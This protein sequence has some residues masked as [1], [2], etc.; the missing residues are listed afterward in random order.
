MPVLNDQ[1][2]TIDALRLQREQKADILYKAQI[3]LNA[4]KALLD[5]AGRQETSLPASGQQITSL[6]S[7]IEDRQAEL[8]EL[9]SEY[10]AI[11]LVFEQLKQSEQRITFLQKKIDVI[12]AQLADANQNL[13]EEEEKQIPDKKIVTALTT[14]IPNLEKLLAEVEQTLTKAQDEDQ[15]LKQEQNAANALK[16]KLNAQRADLQANIE[17]LQDTLA[18]LLQ[19]GNDQSAA[20]IRKKLDQQQ[21]AYEQA[22][23]QAGLASAAV[24]AEV[25]KLYVD[26]HPKAGVSL[27]NDDTPFLLLPVRIETRFMSSGKQPELWLR[28]Y[29][30]DIAIHTHEKLLTTR[31]LAE[32]AVYWKALFEAEKAGGSTKEDMKKAA[33]STLART[34]RPQRSAWIALQTKPTNWDDLSSIPDADALVFPQPALTKPDSWSRAPRVNVLPDRFVITLYEGNVVSKEVVGNII[35]DELFVG[36]DP[37]EPDDSFLTKDDRLGFGESYDWTSDF[38]K[39]IKHGMG[40]K[41]PITA[42]QATKGFTRIIA[43]GV[44]LSASA[45]SGKKMVEDLIDNHHYSPKG[46]SLVPQGAATNNTD[47]NGSG[48][49]KN[50]SLDVSYVSETGTPLFTE[51][52]DCDGRNLADALGIDYTP[53]QN[54]LHSNGADLKE[55]V[56]MNKAL[57]ASTLGYYFDAMLKPVLKDADQD[58]LRDFFVENITGRG[59]LPAIRVGDQPYGILL[60]SNFEQWKTPFTSG[61]MPPGYNFLVRLYAI[62]KHYNDIW[63]GLSAKLSYVGKAGSDPSAALM[64]IIG[65]Q[66][67]SASIYQRIAYTTDY[68]KNLDEFQ[69]GGKYHAD[70]SASITSKAATLGFLQ[71]FGYTG[72]NGELKVPQLLRLIYQHYHTTLDAANIVDNVPLSETDPIS[73]YDEVAKKNYLHWLA[74]IDTID[75]LETEDFGKDVPAPTALM[76]MQLRRSLALQLHKAS[77]LWLKNRN[78]N[79]EFTLGPTN[80][81]NVRPEGNLSKWEVMRGPLSE[82]IPNHPQGKQPVGEYLLRMENDATEAAFLRSV[83][84]SLAFLSSLPT[85]RLERCFMEHLDTC[86]YRLDAWQTGLFNLRLKQQRRL[87]NQGRQLRQQ[88]V[89]LGSYGWVEH[90]TPSTKRKL[91]SDP[92]PKQ[93]QPKKGRKLVEYTDNGGYVHAP[94]LNHASAAAILRSGYMNHASPANPDVMAVNLSSER[95]RRAIFVLDGMRNG[96]ALE[97]LLGY[98]FERGLHDRGSADVALKSLNEYIYNFRDAYPMLYH[99]V[100]QQGTDSLVES[101]P[102][103][104]VVNGVTLATHS[105]GFPFGAT[106]AVVGANADEKKAIV[107]EKDKLADTLD[108]VK[109]L[110]TSE[111]VYQ[112]VQ[113]NF[114]RAG[115]MVNAVKDVLIP[116]HLDVIDTPRGSHF[117]FTNRVIIN[118]G[119]VDAL[120]IANNPWPAIAMTPRAKMEPGVNKWIGSVIGAA[121]TIVYSVSHIDADALP[122]AGEVWTLEHLAVQP[123]DLVYLTGNE[124]STGVEDK[125]SVSELE[126]RIAYQYRRTHGLDDSTAVKIEFK[127]PEDVPG[128]QTFAQLLPLL[129]MLRLL[130]TDSRY[131]HA[132][133]FEPHS[134][135][136]LADKTNPKAFDAA[137]LLSRVQQIQAMYTSAISLVTG[138]P[139]VAHIPD[140]DADNLLTDYNN[141]EDAFSALNKAKL[142]FEDVDFTFENAEAGGLQ[143]LLKAISDFGLADAFP[144]FSTVLTNEVKAVLL[145]QARGIIRRMMVAN[146]SVTTILA[147]PI[148]SIDVDRKITEYVRAG[149]LLLQ[150]AFNILPLFSFNNDADIQLSQSDSAQLV[151][152]AI[153]EGKM[154]YPED[155]WMQNAAHVRPRLSRWDGVR[156]FYELSNAGEL[157]VQALQVPYRKDDSW[158]A[159]EYPKIDPVTNKPFNIVHDTLSIVAHGEP[160]KSAGKQAGLLVDDWTEMMPT[161]EETTGITFNYNQPNAMPPQALLLAVTPEIKGHWT[162]DD[163]MGI[164]NDTLNR[165][166]L[167]AV[168]PQLLDELTLPEINILRPAVIADFTQYDMDVSLDYRRNLTTLEKELAITPLGGN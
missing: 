86:N 130:T 100:A 46:F 133:D 103:N 151:K 124:L 31:E 83:K 17:Q 32:G 2:D 74:G 123:I 41:I 26:P 134:K 140:P 68:L 73:F 18:G 161:N 34:F 48:Y 104:N 102:A 168:E 5:R 150:D 19:G 39:A 51:T 72:I 95:V 154:K 56:A 147:A 27:L 119:H 112:L 109:D 90:V 129:R 47:D 122:Q 117:S 53:L 10:R 137:E 108:A 79:V 125:T 99:H 111:S 62:L 149:K 158:L 75:V 9:D 105:G 106:G 82:V 65:L 50:D 152:Y 59:L 131:L 85:A 84:S 163:L 78:M 11:E 156:S 55:A 127:Q 58:K 139:I 116:A 159:V 71:A 153:T 42:T 118:F 20:D 67:N 36:P 54:V 35:P 144:K 15:Q 164:L 4:T 92:V 22:K 13:G 23:S 113:G 167:R 43:F 30:D 64:D 33:W 87:L 38:D 28:V 45:D 128:K 107:E 63:K 138:M 6:K 12:T 3:Q 136:S 24:T 114:E 14:Q 61:E 97:A 146:A 132:E 155:E 120:D 162:W 141:L 25:G 110:L 49:T 52:D 16:N 93:L 91:V 77:V 44:N 142:S 88:G 135:K 80:F 37:M 66:P 96:Q 101:I 7:D 21:I 165:A 126:S 81:H 69:W 145:E 157:K 148:S 40:F 98:Q 89:Y 94:S 143:D 60:T 1:Q 166:K 70:L 76:F 57:Y 115:A 160:F 29:P 121:D 8:R